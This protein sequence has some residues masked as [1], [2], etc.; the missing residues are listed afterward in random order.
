[1]KA[2]D[3]TLYCCDSQHIEEYA[4]HCGNSGNIC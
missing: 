4:T 2:K 3:E 1:M